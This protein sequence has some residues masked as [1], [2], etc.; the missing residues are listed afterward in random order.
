MVNVYS[1]CDLNKKKA[2]WNKLLLLKDFFKDGEWIMG[3]DFNAIKYSR[4]MKR[5]SV[6]VKQNEVDLFVKFINKS[7]LGD[8]LC[9]R[10]KV[11]LV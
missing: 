6:V 10:K 2:M 4:V 7:A 1:S 3:G 8:F 11:F 5:K 9:K